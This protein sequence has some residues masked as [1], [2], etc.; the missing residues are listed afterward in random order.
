MRPETWPVLEQ[1]KFGQLAEQKVAKALAL[2]NAQAAWL[3]QMSAELASELRASASLT[4]GS[5]AKRPGELLHKG[6]SMVVTSL[7]QL[8]VQSGYWRVL[9]PSY[10]HPMQTRRDLLL[11]QFFE[12]RFG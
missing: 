9:L 7:L 11:E 10:A 3:N 1:A 8:N 5:D 6:S 2:S 4:V 12:L